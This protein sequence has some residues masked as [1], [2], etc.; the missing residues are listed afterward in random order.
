MN[1]DDAHRL[2]TQAAAQITT[3]LSGLPTHDVDTLR[4]S[5]QRGLDRFD[6]AAAAISGDRAAGRAPTRE[7]M[8]DRLEQLVSGAIQVGAAA[9]ALLESMPIDRASLPVMQVF[10]TPRDRRD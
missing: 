1:R 4:D 7:E 5:I 6:A 9:T 10:A 8:R 2:I 3:T